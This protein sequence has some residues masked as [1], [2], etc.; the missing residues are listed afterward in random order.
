M[1]DYDLGAL[2]A[3]EFPWADSGDVI[4]LNH[5]ATGPMPSR[6]VALAQDWTERRRRPWTITDA[7]T[8]FPALRRTREACAHLV[9]AS[10]EEI[11]L[12]PNTSYGLNLAAQSLPLAQG[13]VV[14]SC[15]GEFPTVVAVWEN[16]RERLGID[17]HVVPACGGLPDE[18]ALL[19]AIRAPR[20]KVVCVSWVGYV[21]GA[22]LNLTRLG[23][24]CRERGVWFVV[25]AIQGL[26]AATLDVSQTPVDVLA[27]GAF[28]WLLAPWGAGFCYVRGE[29]IPT[30]RPPAL[31]WL[32][33]PSQE[34]YTRAM[35]HDAPLYDD[36]RRFEVMTLPSQDLAA[37]GTSVGL[38]LE[39][40]AS[41]VA[42]HVSELT[43]LIVAWAAE[44]PGVRLVT[45]AD[46]DRRAGIVS[47]APSDP[48]RVSS[49]LRAAGVI[50][51][52]RPGGVLRISPYLYNTLAEVDAAL[53]RLDDAMR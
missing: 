25:D 51:S 37:M 53:E 23:A 43:G 45:P 19:E 8:V 34:D 40:G 41:R 7:E 35:R 47:V 27:C 33:G 2:R 52:L 16:V 22:R 48:A 38:L 20:V 26:G 17:V 15:E 5:A 32:M 10:A 49:R 6:T 4:Y 46:P 42:A 1:A 50:H 11:A 44:R 3:A 39:L 12:L 36:A 24:A 18:D 9:G 28:K 13:D 29:L 30:M 14:V 31:G 21:H